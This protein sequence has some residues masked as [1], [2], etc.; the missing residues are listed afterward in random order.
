ML[1]SQRKTMNRILITA[2][3]FLAYVGNIQA[4]DDVRDMNVIKSNPNYI[5]ATGTSLT[6]NDE[7][8]QNAKDLLNAEIEDW[9]KKSVESDIAGYIAKSQEQLG[10]IKTKR[11]SLFR[12]FAYVHKADILPYYKDEKVISGSFNENQDISQTEPTQAV[13]TEECIDTVSN[14]VSESVTQ[15]EV[16]ENKPIIVEEPKYIPNDKEKELLQIRTF[17]ELN[18]YINTGRENGTIA[19]LGKYATL[20]KDGL[21]Y[22]FIHNRE[23]AIPACIKINNGVTINLGTGKNDEVSNYKGCGAIWVIFK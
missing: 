21:I 4:Q 8:S 14:K 15:E 17:I 18:N 20:P 13:S 7:A 2:V 9:L 12:V 10:M 22:V 11:G 3:A 23:G 19:Q 16:V 6:S 5:Y 1:K